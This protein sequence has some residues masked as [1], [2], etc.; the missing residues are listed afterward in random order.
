MYGTCAYSFFFLVPFSVLILLPLL[1]KNI[2]TKRNLQERDSHGL[3][4][5]VTANHC[6]EVA[7]GRSLRYLVTSHP[8]SKADRNKFT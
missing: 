7:S 8:P 4:F 3:Q 1:D 6:R 5:Q 2:L